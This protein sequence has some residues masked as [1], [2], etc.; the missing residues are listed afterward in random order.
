[1]QYENTNDS[2]INSNCALDMRALVDLKL[3]FDL[4][5]TQTRREYLCVPFRFAILPLLHVNR[6]NLFIHFLVL[7][8]V[9]NPSGMCAHPTSLAT[10]NYSTVCRWS[11]LVANT[12][13]CP[14]QGTSSTHT[15]SHTIDANIPFNLICVRAKQSPRSYETH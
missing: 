15:H 1:M 12:H 4:I 14:S 2:L 7:L 11:V 9:T 13:A 10:R 6:I 5:R 8:S 3:I